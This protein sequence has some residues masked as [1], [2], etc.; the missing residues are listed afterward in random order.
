MHRPHIVFVTEG[1]KQTFPQ[2]LL[3]TGL[4]RPCLELR[5]FAL[6]SHSCGLQ[7][8]LL[9]L[10]WF[11]L[12]QRTATFAAKHFRQFF[13]R[14]VS[15]PETQF[16]EGGIE[17]RTEATDRA[18]GSEE[19]AWFVPDYM[20][21]DIREGGIAVVRMGVPAAGAQVDL[22]I[23]RSGRFFS[24][25]HDGASKIRAALDAFEA[26]MKN[27]QG[28]A[29]QGSK[30]IANET[31]VLPDGL[32]QPFGRRIVVLTQEGRNAAA[33]TPLGIKTVWDWEHLV[34]AFAPSGL[35]CQAC[36]EQIQRLCCLLHE[37]EKPLC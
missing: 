24:N 23:A 36:F 21:N 28:L 29:V 22:D 30:L 11:E 26:G 18:F 31:L 32:E 9:Q 35:H 14:F 20:E 4:A 19:R 10:R 17:G 13:G 2:G 27:S 12:A 3:P 16:A 37:R 15:Q 34:I 6:E 7:E 33:N 8:Q 25:L 5:G 1:A